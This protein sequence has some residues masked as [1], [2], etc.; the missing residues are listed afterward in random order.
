MNCPVNVG[1]V[2]LVK[3]LYDVDY[4]SGFLCGRGIVKVD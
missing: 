3:V 4:L 2:V 1:I